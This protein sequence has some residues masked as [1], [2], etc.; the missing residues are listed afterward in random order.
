MPPCADACFPAWRPLALVSLRPGPL[1][2]SRPPFDLLI[3]NG[4]VV[5][6]TGARGFAPTSASRGDTI[7]AHRARRST[8]RP[9]ASSTSPARSSRPASS[10]P[11]RTRGAAS[12]QTP[13]ARQLRPAGRDDGHRRAGR[14]SRR[15]PLAPFLAELDKLPKSRQHR[16]P[17]SARDRSGP[18][19]IGSVNRQATPE[20]IVK[21]QALVEQGMSD[22]AF[23]LSTGLFYVPGTFTP[24]ERGR[25]SSRR[26]PAASAASTRRISATTRRSC[27]TACARRSRSARRAACRRRSR[28]RR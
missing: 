18:R 14:Q 26:S 28:T 10:T 11:T 5:D 2:L 16:Q 7:A 13:T 3:K 8:S 6:G 1:R 24:T 12:T 4:R 20:E 19:S 21:M 15:V 9:P 25:S 27:S 22:G 17:S 23:G